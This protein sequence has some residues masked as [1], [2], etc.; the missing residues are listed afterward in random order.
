MLT[1]SKA[2]RSVLSAE[3]L[4]CCIHCQLQ[5]QVDCGSLVQKLGCA[6]MERITIYTYKAELAELLQMHALIHHH[7][8][9]CTLGNSR[10]SFMDYL[11]IGPQVQTTNGRTLDCPTGSNIYSKCHMDRVVYLQLSATGLC[12]VSSAYVRLWAHQ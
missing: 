11:W 8:L 4:I 9:L 5:C 6:W 3:S 2:V 10:Q 12:Q 1:F 7:F